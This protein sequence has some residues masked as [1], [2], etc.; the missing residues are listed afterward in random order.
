[1]DESYVVCNSGPSGQGVSLQAHGAASYEGK[2]GSSD[3]GG[4]ALS[5]GRT[6][7]NSSGSITCD[8]SAR[9]ITCI[10][11]NGNRFVIGDRYVRI[12][13]NG[14]ERRIDG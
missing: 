13:N 12:R 8:S 10:T 5:F 4:P 7:T 6:V 14:S 9:G 1:M 3:R 2:T 11:A